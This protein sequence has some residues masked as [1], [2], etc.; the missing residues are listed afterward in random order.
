[1]N[2]SWVEVV[3]AAVLVVDAER[4][5]LVKEYSEAFAADGLYLEQKG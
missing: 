3:L 4:L 2:D 5:A 1:V